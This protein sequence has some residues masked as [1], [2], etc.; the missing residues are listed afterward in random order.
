[1]IKCQIFIAN[2]YS[3]VSLWYWRLKASNGKVIADGA[4]GYSSQSN[5][6]KSFRTNIMKGLVVCS[7][8]T[9]EVLDQQGKVV[10]TVEA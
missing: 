4:E 9:I 6:I 2:P 10:K 3:K 1:M 5:A 8:I 7:P